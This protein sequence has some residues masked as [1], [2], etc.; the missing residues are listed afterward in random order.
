MKELK[1]VAKDKTTEIV[2][3]DVIGADEWFGGG[4]SSKQFRD[5]VKGVK[6]PDIELRIN[7]PGGDVFEAVAMMAAVDGFKGTVTAYV[8]GLAASAASVLAM[9]ADRIVMADGSMMMIH[10]PYTI[11]IGGVDELSRKIDLLAN[12][13]YDIV[14]AYKRQSSLSE[15]KI[16]EMMSKE[17]WMTAKEAVDHGFAH[18]LNSSSRVAAFADVSKCGYRHAPKLKAPT[19][20][21]DDW[22]KHNERLAALDEM[23][24]GAA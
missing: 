5:A 18:E 23:L 13:K 9:A 1:I 3:Y 11:V 8:D 20:T 15:K 14:K 6:T 2:L 12:I 17:T 4:V 16:G 21:A 7:S 10:D 19:F 22:K 24:K